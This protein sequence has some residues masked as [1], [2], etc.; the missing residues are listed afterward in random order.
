MA[1][2]WL[3]LAVLVVLGATSGSAAA[4][5]PGRNGTIVYGWSAA[6]Q[7]RAAPPVSAIRTIDPRT[8]QV[9]QLRE[10]LLRMGPPVGDPECE[11]GAPR[12]SPDGT[13]IAFL[14]DQRTYPPGGQP[15]S[16]PGIG[17]MASDGT[18][19][20]HR[21]TATGYG[22]LAWA[23]TGDQLL[24][25]RG[26]PTP[27]ASRRG[28]IFLASPE[29]NEIRQVTPE[30]SGAPDWASTGEIA[31]VRYRDYPCTR[32]CSNIWLTRLGGTPRRLT[33]R[34]GDDPS[35]SPHGTR[36][37]FTRVDG[38]RRRRGIYLVRR[39]GRGLRQLT[40]GGHGPSWSP[41]GRWIAYLR[42]GD[43]YVVRRD[44]RVT[45]RLVDEPWNG[46]DGPRAGALDWQPLPRP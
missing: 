20:E 38:A 5:F 14:A 12:Y 42:A 21:A 11:V 31:F 28:A 10:C 43:I 6:G 8:G 17:V 29:G 26:F 36:L 2:G 32:L 3:S 24:V 41:D 16:Q 40:R 9:R 13:R 39:D 7:Y 18:G 46:L 23:P 27:D 45:R 25:E 19:F 33:R 30:G 34:G 35:W 4:S 1:R 44:G 22:A 15:Q 37:A